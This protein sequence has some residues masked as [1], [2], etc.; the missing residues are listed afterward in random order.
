MTAMAFRKDNYEAT[1]LSGAGKKN[2]N[3][4]DDSKKPRNISRLKNRKKSIQKRN[5]ISKT[6]KTKTKKKTVVKQKQ[7][8]RVIPLGGLGE[9]GKNLTVFETEK[10]IILVDCGLK[11]PDED[12]YGIDSVI[13]EFTYLIE[14]KNKIRGLFITHGHEDHIG[15]IP[16]LLKNVDVPIYGTRL[17]IGLLKRKLVEHGPEDANLNVVKAG[18]RIKVRGFS[19]EFIQSNHSIPDSCCLCIK[20][21]DYTVLH[22][23]DFKIDFTP[24]DNQQINLQRIAEIGIEG[25]DLLLAD[26]TNAEKEG[27]S[28]SEANV[29]K[30]FMQLFGNAEK[31]RIILATFA[32]NI[33]RI[34]QVFDTAEVY[35][36][37]VALSG[38]SM[39]N[40]VS[41]AKELGYLKFRDNTLIDLR[42][43]D[44]YSPKDVIILTTGSQGEPMAALS[45]MAKGEHRQFKISKHD[46]V[47]ISAIPIPGNEKLVADV[48]NGIIEM[49][50]D[51]VY[52]GED[53]IHVSGHACQE[54][55]K[56]MNTLVK[57]KYFLPA[58]GENKMLAKHKNLAIELGMDENDVFVMKNGEV[59][60]LSEKGAKVTGEV[61]NGIVMVDGLGIGDV[62]NIVLKDRKKLSEDGLFIIVVSITREKVVSGPGIVSRGFVYMR[63]SEE[64]LNGAKDIVNRILSGY[65]GR[66]YDYNS[67]KADIKYEIERYLFEKTRRRPMILPV[68]MYVKLD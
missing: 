8:L 12:M 52:H 62:G 9:I 66:M 24:V 59:L 7:K 49:G 27:H 45:R 31:K 1:Y 50:A 61:P 54:E 43:V 33:H 65:E 63:E 47:I 30:T 36:R 58:H 53:N 22:T 29:G 68:L 48:I 38:R 21:D 25:V 18:D 64:L 39:V 19:V 5:K 17:T 2:T 28:K 42:D 55:L 14:R 20:T 23:G 10:D 67:I 4:T 13:P 41:V 16:Y 51:V 3:S 35:K 44:N 32:T 37:K 34:Q 6:S 11:F 60:E 26:S 15:G 46:C 40:V 57:P 56:L